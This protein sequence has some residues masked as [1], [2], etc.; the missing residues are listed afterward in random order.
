[1]TQKVVTRSLQAAALVGFAA[2]ASVIVGVLFGGSAEPLQ[3]SDPG[4]VVRWGA[5][6]VKLVL[7]LSMATAIGTLVLSAFAGNPQERQRLQP[8]ASWAAA[9]WLAASATY[10]V[11]TYLSASGTALSY[12]RSSPRGFGYLP[13]RS[14]SGYC[15]RLIP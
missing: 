10:F 4:P 11:M 6:L 12:G 9:L 3:F 14:S 15:W 2:L 13:P 8:L 1:L 7:N 5:P